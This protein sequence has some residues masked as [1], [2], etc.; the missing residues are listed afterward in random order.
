MLTKRLF[1]LLLCCSILYLSCKPGHFRSP[2][3][4]VRYISDPAHGLV[5]QQQEQDT[6]Y[7]AQLFPIDY[8]LLLAGC[9]NGTVNCDSLRRQLDSC[10]YFR[11]EMNGKRIP[12]NV[13]Y[14]MANQFTLQSGKDTLVCGLCQPIA[15]GKASST[16]YMLVFYRRGAVKHDLLLKYSQHAFSFSQRNF[17]VTLY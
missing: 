2:E 11:F 3:K 10:Y 8:Q 17:D 14:D 4:F 1:Y 9:G 16:E 6:V 7:T 15:N 5:Q 12:E 13:T